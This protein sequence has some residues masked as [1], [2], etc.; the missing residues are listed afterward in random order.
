MTFRVADAE[1][2]LTG[3]R[4]QA[5]A[6]IPADQLTFRRA[7]TGWEL[8]LDLPPVARIE[9]LLELRYPGG[10]SKV[11]TDPANPRQA[12]GAFGPKSVLELPGYAAPAWLTAAG[13]PGTVASLAVPVFEAAIS[14][15]IW[16]PARAL[17]DEPLPLLVAHDGP[18]YDALASLTGY[19]AA[20]MTGGWLPRLRA[21]LLSPGPR[22]S[23]Y[24]ANSRYAS[25]LCRSVLPV[26]GRHVATTRRI[27]MGTSF[28][29]LAMLHAHCRYP[30]SF[31][32]LFLQSGSF[33]V[34]R[35]DSQERRFPHY[36]RIIGFTAD[37]HAGGLPARP[38]PVVHT[39]GAI[40]ENAA[41][42]RLMR[43]TLRAHDYPATL[44]EVRDMHNYTAWR[45]AFDPYLTSLLQQV[46]P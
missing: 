3:V 22:N 26:L 10:G 6:G 46:S 5:D 23:W 16:S 44:H 34:P 13:E 20:G 14:A 43:A 31:D 40:E 19:L 7:G 37:V 15:R 9:Y 4:L 35:L 41:N 8:R 1:H 32:A 25:A 36:R 18:E 28:G 38:V 17:P 27:G 2:A 24:S 30:G 29:G 12:A 21:A 39:C 45:D 33:F 11:V 42:N